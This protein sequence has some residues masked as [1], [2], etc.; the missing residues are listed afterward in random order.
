MERKERWDKFKNPPKPDDDELVENAVVYVMKVPQSGSEMTAAGRTM[1]S[2]RRAVGSLRHGN[3][4]HRRR[5]LLIFGLVLCV[6]L[7]IFVSRAKI[8]R[9]DVLF[10]HFFQEAVEIKVERVF[11][12]FQVEYDSCFGQD[13]FFDHPP[14]GDA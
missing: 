11:K 6:L 12:V 1:V 2:L 10:P 3:G 8:C 13:A 14:E 4:R 7:K 5:L 9:R